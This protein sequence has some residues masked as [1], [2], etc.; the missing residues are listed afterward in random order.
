MVVGEPSLAAEAGDPQ[1]AGH[2]ALAGGEDGA[3]QQQLGMAPRS[4]LQEQRGES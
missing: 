1:Q 4:L 2:G 3:D